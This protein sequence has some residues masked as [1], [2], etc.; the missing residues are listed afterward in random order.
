M[1]GKKV[2]FSPP[3]DM[4]RRERMLFAQATQ[5]LLASVTNG[6]ISFATE[7]FSPQIFHLLITPDRIVDNRQN[8]SYT[9]VVFDQPDTNKQFEP[10]IRQMAEIFR[11]PWPQAH[12]QWSNEAAASVLIND[13]YLADNFQNLLMRSILD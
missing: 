10:M 9:H 1:A 2:R 13:T 4:T 12:A 8:K 6:P 7:H 3:A 5:H 11:Q